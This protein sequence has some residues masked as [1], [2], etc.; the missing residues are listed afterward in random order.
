MVCAKIESQDSVCLS[1]PFL[2]SKEDRP[3][4]RLYLA[5]RIQRI[6]PARLTQTSYFVAL[7]VVMLQAISVYMVAALT[8]IA[9]YNYNAVQCLLGD[10]NFRML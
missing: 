5:Q 3:R 7:L 6:D 10:S 4:L 1:H 8:I 2:A 9:P